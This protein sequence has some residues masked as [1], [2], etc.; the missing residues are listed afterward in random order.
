[1]RHRHVKKFQI[2]R[3]M[4]KDCEGAMNVCKGLCRPSNSACL[5]GFI[6]KVEMCPSFSITF[7]SDI[8]VIIYDFVLNHR[9]LDT[10]F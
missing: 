5:Q 2:D 10:P 6:Q 8:Q 3:D 4:I 9:G 1:M 7:T